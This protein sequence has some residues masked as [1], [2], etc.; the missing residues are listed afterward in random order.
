[1]RINIDIKTASAAPA[2]TFSYHAAR[3][4]T[5]STPNLVRAMHPSG[6]QAHAWTVNDSDKMHALP[7][8]NVEGLN[9]VLPD[10][11]NA[12]VR[13]FIRRHATHG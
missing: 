9:S 5:P 10:T 6:Q 4:P 13:H 2:A 1:M 11:S 3:S 8:I 7:D 12:A